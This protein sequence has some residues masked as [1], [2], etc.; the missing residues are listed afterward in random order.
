MRTEKEA[1][2]LPFQTMRAPFYIVGVGLR[3]P[4][5][6][7]RW[8]LCRRQQQLRG[9]TRKW[10][11]RPL[12]AGSRCVGECCGGIIDIVVPGALSRRSRSHGGESESVDDGGKA[13]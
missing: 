1:E 5:R 9:C 3:G 6:T 10:R 2:K 12:F 4:A 7:N 8:K 11:Q 13:W